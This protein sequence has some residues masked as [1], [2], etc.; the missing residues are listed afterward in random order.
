MFI[1]KICI[2]SWWWNSL[3]KIFSFPS[4]YTGQKLK[5]HDYIEL[6]IPKKSERI[7]SKKTVEIEE[8]PWNI[9]K[10][11]HLTKSLQPPFIIV[12][13]FETII[14]TSDN[15]SELEELKKVK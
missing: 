13:D 1:S 4:Y 7:L 12:Y 11:S 10:Y 3:S 5:N 6:K 8:M 2:K 15:Q 9:L 14:V